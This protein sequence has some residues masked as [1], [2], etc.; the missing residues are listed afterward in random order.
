MLLFFS[1][2]PVDHHQDQHSPLLSSNSKVNDNDNS[3]RRY[4]MK[5]V[6]NEL[7]LGVEMFL[8]LLANSSIF[9]TFNYPHIPYMTPREDLL[10]EGAPDYLMSLRPRGLK[11]NGRR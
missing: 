5:L 6:E 2:S 10:Q 4:G 8:C 3:G 11:N 1:F 7:I 9:S